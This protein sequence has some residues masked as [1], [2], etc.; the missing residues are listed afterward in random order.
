PAP[1]RTASGPSKTLKPMKVTLF[2]VQ[3]RPAGK[4]LV[5]PAGE[6][7]FGRGPECHVRPD[8]EWVSRQ[9]CVLRVAGDAVFLR[10]LGSRNGTLVNGVLL[11]RERE[12][13][14]KDLIQIGP[15]VFE[16]DYTRSDLPAER[17]HESADMIAAA[18]TLPLHTARV[19]EEETDSILPSV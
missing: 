13:Q 12:L 19:S 17:S 1:V 16:V 3:G 9:H 8:S 14:C 2:V 11:T 10:D 7:F 6:Y 4:K 18:E 5:F 15:L